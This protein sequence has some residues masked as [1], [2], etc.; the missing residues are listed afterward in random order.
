MNGH[1]KEANE[2]LLDFVGHT[3][4]HLG[5]YMFCLFWGSSKESH[6]AGMLVVHELF[7]YVFLSWIISM[8]RL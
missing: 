2:K 8:T 6:I 5:V 7:L 4:G 3:W 1:V